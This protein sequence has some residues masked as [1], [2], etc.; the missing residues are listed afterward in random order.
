MQGT[1]NSFIRN[2]KPQRVRS[3]GFETKLA[4]KGMKRAVQDARANERNRKGQ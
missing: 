2:A 4:R 1:N 3:E